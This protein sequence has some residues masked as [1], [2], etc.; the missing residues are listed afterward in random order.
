[1][2]GIL[3]DAYGKYPSDDIDRTAIME[4][5]NFLEFLIPFNEQPHPT[6][7]DTWIRSDPKIM[8]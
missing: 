4:Y 3:K 5:D 6:E 7:F 8:Q 1:M 2:T